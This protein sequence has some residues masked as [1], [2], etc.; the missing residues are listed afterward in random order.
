MED[1]EIA[2]KRHKKRKTYCFY[3]PFASFRGYA[4][5]PLCSLCCG[6]ISNYQES[7]QL[8]VFHA[9]HG[10]HQGLGVRASEQAVDVLFLLEGHHGADALLQERWLEPFAPSR[11]PAICPSVAGTQ[12]AVPGWTCPVPPRIPVR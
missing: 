1:D 11:L 7:D 9:L 5:F 4:L 3:A 6:L 12:S 8:E 2:A 10:V